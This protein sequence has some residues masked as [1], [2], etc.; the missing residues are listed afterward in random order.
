MYLL[1]LEI[2]YLFEILCI[3]LFNLHSLLLHREASR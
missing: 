3:D 1:D 2:A